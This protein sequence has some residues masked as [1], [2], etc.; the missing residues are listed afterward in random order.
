MLDIN[1]IREHP[2]A[3]RDSLK[4]RGDAEK[5]KM[6]NELIEYDKKWRQS[7]TTLNRVRHEKNVLTTEIAQLKKEGKDVKQKIQQVNEIEQKIDKLK[8]EVGKHKE[9]IN[10]ILLRLPN[11]LHDSVPIGKDENDNVEI[12]VWGKPPKFDFQP[13]SHLEIASN[14]G[15]LDAERA[16]K[17]AGA[18]FYY[19]K[20]ELVLLDLAIQRFA[21]DSLMKKDFTLIE[22]PL[23]INKKAYEGMIG[24][25]FDFTEASYKVE[26]TEFYLIPT[27]EYPL[28]SMFTDEVLDKKTLPIKLVGLSACFRKEIGTHGKYTKGLFRMHQF[29]KVEQFILCLPEQSWDMFKEIQRNSEELYQKLGLHHRVVSL[30]SGDMTA[31]AAKAYDIE[32]WMAD[33]EFRESGTN[34]NCT[35]Y[36][37]RRLNIRFR[38]KEGQAPA[39]FVHTLNNTALATSRTMIAIL[40]QF[41]QRDGSVIIPKA[42]RPFMGG[43]ERIG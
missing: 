3:V 17:A 24:D 34:S 42:L 19:L 22:P 38:E 15:L 28:G 6:L 2:D 35:D 26:D 27:A 33:G 39:G 5:L 7:L 11:I 18:G 37:A 21:I 4:R 12:R 40:E 41:Q 9:N 43:I 31:K 10:H 25:P 8:E 20:N 29:N 30:C 16:A 36:Q 23:M 32:V 14:L 13:K 1:L